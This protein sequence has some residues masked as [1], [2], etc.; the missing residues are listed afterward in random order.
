M[1]KKQVRKDLSEIN[2]LYPV[3]KTYCNIMLRTKNYRIYK[4]NFKKLCKLWR[5]DYQDYID[6]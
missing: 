3:A 6:K 1:D 4:K 5:Y 2:D